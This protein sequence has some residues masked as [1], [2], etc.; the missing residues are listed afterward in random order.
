MVSYPILPPSPHF[1]H[2]A[3]SAWAPSLR[4][5]HRPSGRGLQASWSRR[6][7]SATI[8]PAV[9]LSLNKSFLAVWML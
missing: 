9:I 5:A 6:L 2:P 4:G 8:P 3:P 7:P 1:P